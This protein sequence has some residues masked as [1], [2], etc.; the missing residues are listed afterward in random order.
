M[1]TYSRFFIE[2]I[3]SL[4][5]NLNYNKKIINKIFLKKN[6]KYRIFLLYLLLFLIILFSLNS[7]IFFTFET[8]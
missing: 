7:L 3:D 2:F 6:K 8:K 5:K 4:K 1:V